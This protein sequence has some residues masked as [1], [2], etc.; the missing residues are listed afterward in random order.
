[1]IY[2]NKT[3]QGKN[4]GFKSLYFQIHLLQE[5]YLKHETKKGYFQI[6]SLLI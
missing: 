3:K 5:N 2:K 6:M 4:G 1:M